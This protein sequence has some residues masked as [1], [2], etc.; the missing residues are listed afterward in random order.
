MGAADAGSAPGR[1]HFQGAATVQAVLRPGMVEAAAAAGLRSLF[2]GFETLSEENLRSQRKKQNLGRDYATAIRR[3]HDNGVMVTRTKSRALG[4]SKSSL[5][6]VTTPASA[7][8]VSGTPAS[9]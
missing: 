9:M 2:V 8:P 7:G 1:H 3:L 4:Y 6:G 5:T